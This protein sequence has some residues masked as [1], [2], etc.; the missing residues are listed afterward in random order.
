MSYDNYNSSTYESRIMKE[1]MII[2]SVIIIGVCVLVYYINNNFG[3]SDSANSDTDSAYVETNFSSS[4]KST[5]VR[6]CIR[7]YLMYFRTSP[8]VMRC[9]LKI[10]LQLKRPLQLRILNKGG[11]CIEEKR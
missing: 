6:R 10:V 2:I 3:R 8:L 11:V 9:H 1:V 7:C 5:Q 4:E